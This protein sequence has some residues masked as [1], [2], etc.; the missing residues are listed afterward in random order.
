MV[1]T[2]EKTLES[3]LIYDGKILK[4]FRDTAE[5]PDGRSAIREVVRKADGVCIAAVDAEGRIAFVSQFR[6]PYGEDVLELPAGKIDG[7]EDPDHAALRELKE[8]TGVECGKLISLGCGMSSPGFCDESLWL[9]IAA[10]LR[11]GEAVPDEGEFLNLSWISLEKAEEMALTG[12]IKD[13]KSRM[14]ILAAAAYLRKEA[15]Q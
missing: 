8:E 9:Y 11:K 1:K 4:L 15:E 7:D 3:E 6:Y 2:E 13:L 12:E 5:L 14:L 10:D